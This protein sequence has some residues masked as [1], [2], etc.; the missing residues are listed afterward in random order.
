VKLCALLVIS[1]VKVMS[2]SAS[3]PYRSSFAFSCNVNKINCVMCLKHSVRPHSCHCFLCPGNVA[4][5][6]SFLQY[7]LP[8]G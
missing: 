7:Y 5:I 3:L 4:Q 1:W 8:V 2:S 6:F